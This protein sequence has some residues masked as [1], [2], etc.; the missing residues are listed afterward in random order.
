MP[1]KIN[2][3][4]AITTAALG[5]A[6]LPIAG[7]TKTDTS[8]TAQHSAQEQTERWKTGPDPN[9]QRDLTPGNTPVRLACKSRDTDLIYP[10]NESIHEIVKRI[11]DNGYTSTS[12]SS[13][14]GSR[15]K[16][17][18]APDSVVSETRSALK[19][20]D[21][22]L[23]DVMVWTNLIHPDPAQRQKNLS[24]VAESIE[25]ADRLGCRMVTMITGSCGAGHYTEWHPDNWTD[26]TWGET[27]K[28]LRQLIS[29]TAGC[30]TSLGIEACVMTNINDPFSNRKIVDD[31]GDPRCRICLDPTNMATLHNYY[32]STELLNECFDRLGELI[33]GCHAKD[34]LLEQKMYVFL[35]EVPP[36][37]GVQ[38]YETYLVRMSRLSWPRT[39]M[40]EHFPAEEYPPAKAYIEETARKVGVT[41]YG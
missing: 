22:E 7:C 11:R 29:D 20:L 24:Y 2:R 37:K 30:K 33:T 6:A 27:V 12:F 23:F 16:W 9:L 19:E 18:D 34:Q 39:L 21:V 5:S 35:T 25:C 13:S 28:V 3:R 10:E 41:I 40:L 36:G 8:T 15:S 14:Y 17:L 38:D 26:K 31:V 32:H 1:V 4:K